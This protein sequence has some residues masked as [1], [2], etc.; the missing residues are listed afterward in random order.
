VCPFTDTTSHTLPIDFPWRSAKLTPPCTP[1]RSGGEQ[2][3][4]PAAALAC[5]ESVEKTNGR[6][7]RGMDESGCRGVWLADDDLHGLDSSS[8]TAVPRVKKERRHKRGNGRRVLAFLFSDSD[9]RAAERRKSDST[10]G[11]VEPCWLF[12]Y[13]IYVQQREERGAWLAGP[14]C[15]ATE[16]ERWPAGVGVTL[17]DLAS[18][19]STCLCLP[20]PNRACATYNDAGSLRACLGC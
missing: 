18:T 11:V 10:V 6:A 7:T 19:S 8:L 15:P 17:L 4:R 14:I 9:M 2:W 20:L 16:I 12:C 5:L 1:Y 3:E 13:L